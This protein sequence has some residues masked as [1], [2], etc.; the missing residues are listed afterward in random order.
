MTGWI[1]N[2]FSLLRTRC[3]LSNTTLAKTALKEDR[4]YIGTLLTKFSAQTT[5]TQSIE[6]NLNYRTTTG[7]SLNRSMKKVH[8][9]KK[10]PTA[11]CPTKTIIRMLLHMSSPSTNT[12]TIALSTAHSISCQSSVDCSVLSAASASSS[13]PRSTTSAAFSLSWRTT[14]STET[15]SPTRTMS[16]GTRSIHS[17]WTSTRSYPS[18]SYAAAWGH[19]RNSVSVL[20][21]TTK[22]CTRRPF[23][24]SF[25]SFASSLLPPKRYD[26]PSN[27][28]D[29]RSMRLSRLRTWTPTLIIS[30]W[31]GLVVKARARATTSS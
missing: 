7:A 21:A 15:A 1:T 29:W 22:F 16:N 23:R 24:T 20:A 10:N 13:S 6:W 25:S 14:S 27:G 5:C 19:R 2:L 30:L 3:I 26:H 4:K 28:K 18:G 11:L 17:Y 8:K 9:L 31:L 12:S